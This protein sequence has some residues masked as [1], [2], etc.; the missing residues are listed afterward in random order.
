MDNQYEEMSA[1]RKKTHLFCKSLE[2][3]SNIIVRK[4]LENDVYEKT[5]EKLKPFEAKMNECKTLNELL[6]LIN[7]N[8]M[9]N[10]PK[11]ES[12][13]NAKE[14]FDKMKSAFSENQPLDQ[15]KSDVAEIFTPA[16]AKEAINDIEHDIAVENSNKLNSYLAGDK[17]NVFYARKV[18]ETN[19]SL[20]R[21]NTDKDLELPTYIVVN[22]QLQI[23]S[24]TKIEPG[25]FAYLGSQP[26]S[27]EYSSIADNIKESDIKTNCWKIGDIENAK[28]LYGAK[29]IDSLVAQPINNTN[30]ETIQKLDNKSFPKVAEVKMIEL[31]V[32]L[33]SDL[34]IKHGNSDNYPIISK[35]WQGKETMVNSA[36]FSHLVDYGKGEIA[37]MSSNDLAKTYK[38]TKEPRD[39]EHSKL[40]SNREG[41]FSINMKKIEFL[42]LD[43][44]PEFLLT[45]KDNQ[46]I[47]D[48][49]RDLTKEAKD[50]GIGRPGE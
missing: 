19:L 29:A 44:T 12:A 37:P 9:F 1:Y 8:E 22:G 28:K 42:F 45:K 6:S 27:A 48:F 18:A 40:F 3:S 43:A 7:K 47:K 34:S 17:A 41:G 46:F 35:D 26:L 4:H 23:E 20:I 15:V 2:N 10:E 24:T 21:N 31:T 5:Q 25:K 11:T 36:L 14:Y 50:Q 32:K 39:Q 16:F 49:K 13:N 33:I 38:V 30:I